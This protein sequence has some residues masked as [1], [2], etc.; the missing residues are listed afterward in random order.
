MSFAATERE[1]RYRFWIFGAIFWLAFAL[2]N[3]DKQN[4]AAALANAFARLMHREPTFGVARAILLAGFAL[5]VAGAVL[6]TWGTAYLRPEVMTDGALHTHTVLADG[7]FRYVRNPLYLGTTLVAFGYAAM[8][9]RL[10]ALVLVVG[11]TF[12][13]YRI[14]LR[15]ERELT[16]A[17]GENY[18][19]YRRAVPRLLPSPWPR[20]AS[21]GRKPDWAWG[22]LGELFMWGLAAAL[23]VFACTFSLRLYFL[24]L[25]LS[26]GVHFL[27]VGI[28]GR[29]RVRAGT[30]RRIP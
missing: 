30:D 1:F 15:E 4:S 7:P 23:L 10:G 6:R 13:H 9:S 29:R 18:E 8:A 26:F 20:V 3:V 11:V 19:R 17:Q 24:T 16:L 27:A 21:S 5:A 2:Y 12:F 25:G 14:I 22:L 28:I